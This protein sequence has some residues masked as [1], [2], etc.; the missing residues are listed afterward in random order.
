MKSIKMNWRLDRR[1]RLKG[2]VWAPLLLTIVF[3]LSV[4]V[5]FY[6]KGAPL[7]NNGEATIYQDLL[8]RIHQRARLLVLQATSKSLFD[9]VVSWKIPAKVEEA[10]EDCVPVLPIIKQEKKGTFLSERDFYPVGL[11]LWSSLNKQEKKEWE[12][13]FEGI[14]YQFSLD[15]VQDL[16]GSANASMKKLS[17]FLRTNGEG[18]PL[19]RTSYLSNREL[20]WISEVGE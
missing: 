9:D 17:S 4:V 6:Q 1:A 2:F 20:P 8:N 15:S 3:S 18:L 12:D 19:R 16:D 11:S 5:Y 13:K 7:N 10:L 14:C